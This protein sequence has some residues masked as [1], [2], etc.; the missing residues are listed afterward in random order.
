MAEM[1]TLLRSNSISIPPKKSARSN[2]IEPTPSNFTIHIILTTISLFRRL[3]NVPHT[4]YNAPPK[5]IN[6]TI[7]YPKKKKT[8]EKRKR[9]YVHTRLAPIQSINRPI[10]ISLKPNI[11]RNVGTTNPLFVQPTKAQ[12]G[13]DGFEPHSRVQVKILG[14]A[15]DRFGEVGALA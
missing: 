15:V 12:S 11:T 6:N 8:R 5:K 7:H 3:A 10:T 13:P 14:C 9:L 2:I 4:N 1:T